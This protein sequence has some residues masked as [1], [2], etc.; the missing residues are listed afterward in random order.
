[1]R[2][3]L[4]VSFV[5]VTGCAPLQQAPLMYTSKQVLGVDIS[6]PTT[7]STGVTLNLGFKN[8]DAAYVP[9]A[10]SREKDSEIKLVSASYG[11]GDSDKLYTD[12][13]QQERIKKYSDALRKAE[14][15]RAQ[16]TTS[17]ANHNSA[18]AFNAAIDASSAGDPVPLN[19]ILLDLSA[20]SP[21]PG[22][23]KSKINPPTKFTSSDLNLLD[24]DAKKFEQAAG[25]A[26]KDLNSAKEE[27]A[28][29]L[30]VARKDAMSVYG[31]FDS[32]TQTTQT[33]VKLG[34]MFSTGVAA[35]NLTEGARAASAAD[36]MNGCAKLAEQISEAATK[37]EFIK[38]CSKDAFGK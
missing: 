25:D 14:T 4:L 15:A 35:Q 21:L 2:V 37:L 1:M 22:M 5:L 9:I 20:T 27:L 13:L 32:N 10:V 26:E 36:L 11:E 33:G 24:G 34:K 18:L 17:L 31:S 16:A 30:Y 19:Q 7:E 23:F 29:S 8:V 28:E 6:A 12:T 38:N 3:A